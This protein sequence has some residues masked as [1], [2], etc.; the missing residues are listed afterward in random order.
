MRLTVSCTGR[1]N[2]VASLCSLRALLLGIDREADAGLY[3]FVRTYLRLPQDD[4]PTISIE[5]EHTLSAEPAARQVVVRSHGQTFSDLQAQEVSRKLQN[6]RIVLFYISTEHR[7]RYYRGPATGSMRDLS[8]E[9]AH[10]VEVMQKMANRGLNRIAKAYQKD[11]VAL[12]GRLDEKYKVGLTLP[13]FDFSYLP[14]NLTLGDAKIDVT[15]DEWGSGTRNRTLILLTLFRA[16]QISESK[17]SAA[18][19]TP[20]IVVEEPESFL[21]PSAQAQF[22]KVLQD[23]AEEFRV[24]V[25]A[26]TH[27]PYMLSLSRPDSNILL[28]RRIE[29]HQQRQTIRVPTDGD[30]WMEPFARALG[31]SNDDFAPWREMFFTGVETVL[32]VEGDT[33]KEYFELLKAPDHGTNSLPSDVEIFAYGGRDNLRKGILLKFLKN[34]SRNIFVTYDLDARDLVK[35]TLQCLGFEDKKDA[36]AIGHD[37]AGKR[38]IEG[39]LPECVLQRV[40][41]ANGALLQAAM[42]GTTEEKNSARQRLKHLYLDDF[43]ANATPTEDYFKHLYQVARMIRK[44]FKEQDR[45]V[46]EQPPGTLYG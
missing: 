8:D 36:C 28:E 31:L 6:S 5:V 24:Q 35:D 22:G 16:K 25:I 41:A 15:L 1:T 13:T 37:V 4:T 42:H 7:P 46:A 40:H 10:E 14:F 38:N 45:K 21:H 19:I 3:E 39:F 29:R 43:K 44:A 20:I 34:R 2:S 18:K 9:F 12:L 17:T 33:D 11:I 23:L 30:R 27:S 32:L 26:T